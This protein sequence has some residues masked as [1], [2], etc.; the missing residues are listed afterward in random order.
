MYPDQ[1][2]YNSLFPNSTYYLHDDET[3]LNLHNP[4]S[5]LFGGNHHGGT[6]AET[7]GVNGK[8]KGP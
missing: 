4:V 7:T 6:G 3:S 8:R 1:I 5:Y 2:K